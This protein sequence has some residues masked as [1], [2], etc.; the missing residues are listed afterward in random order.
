M[1]LRAAMVLMI[2]LALARVLAQAVPSQTGRS[3]E[4]PAPAALDVLQLQGKTIRVYQA[5]EANQG[6]AAASR[7]FFVVDN[8]TLAKYDIKTG[9]MIRRWTGGSNGPI[10]HMNSCMAEGS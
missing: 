5:A 8:Y 2:P 3:G 4:P 6:V 7:H 9:E 1:R 10:R